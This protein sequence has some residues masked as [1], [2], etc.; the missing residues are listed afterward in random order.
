MQKIHS[1][2]LLGILAELDSPRLTPDRLIDLIAR[3]D[4]VEGEINAHRNLPK[5]PKTT[6][7]DPT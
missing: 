4:Q 5:P 6:Q 1:L 3:L 2:K 7:A